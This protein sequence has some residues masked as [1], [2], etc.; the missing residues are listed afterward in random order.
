MHNCIP[1]GQLQTVNV[2][3]SKLIATF[4]LQTAVFNTMQIGG[5]TDEKQRDCIRRVLQIVW[6]V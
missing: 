6:T 4:S 2:A 5:R 1:F 3:V